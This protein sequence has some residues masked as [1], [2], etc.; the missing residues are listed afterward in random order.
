VAELTKRCAKC[1]LKPVSEFHKSLSEKDGLQPYCKACKAESQRALRAKRK[2]NRLEGCDQ[3]PTVEAHISEYSNMMRK[4]ARAA[5][6]H[7]GPVVSEFGKRTSV[8]GHD[9]WVDVDVD[10]FFETR[11]AGDDEVLSDETIRTLQDVRDVV[12]SDERIKFEQGRADFDWARYDHGSGKANTEWDVYD[13]P[14]ARLR[15]VLVIPDTHVPYEDKRAWALML[16]VASAWRPDTIVILGDFCDFYSV[17]SHDK[18]PQRVRMLD[19][20]ITCANER[21]S[22]LDALGATEKYY[23]SGNHEDRLERY[24]AQKAP[25]LF[26]MVKTRDLL[27]LDDRGWKFT[28][29]K[30][31]LKLG[32]MNYTHDCG[33]AGATAHSKALATFQHNITIGHTHR[34]AVAY[35]GNAQGESHVGTM[36]GWLGDSSKADY[37]HEVSILTNWQLGFGTYYQEPN[38]VTHAVPVP[39]V[40]YKCV[41]EGRLFVG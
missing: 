30:S 8:F 9:G 10:D 19:E 4:I 13:P 39:V 25:E 3:N 35:A 17:S 14:A 34:M 11:P 18:N 27:K 31:S 5:T 41:V 12:L 23:I 21:L 16:Q 38:G 24:L 37:M 36:L 15:K 6:K 7:Y 28:P 22:E 32:K 29:Y 20:E 1:G 33:N 2:A 26:N 40:G